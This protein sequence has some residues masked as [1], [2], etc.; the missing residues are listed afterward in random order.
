M[1]P[2]EQIDKVRTIVAKLRQVPRD[3]YDISP[4]QRQLACALDHLANVCESLLDQE[5]A[6]AGQATV[7]RCPKC[8]H[9]CFAANKPDAGYI[10]WCPNCNGAGPVDTPIIARTAV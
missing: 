9:Q 7:V 8:A 6:E 5:R 4:T 1:S 3:C 2:A 10:Y